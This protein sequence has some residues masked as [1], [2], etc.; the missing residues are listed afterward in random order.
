MLSKSLIQFYVD[1]LGCVPS[2]LFDPRTN[3]S[4]GNED[5][6]DLPQKVQQ[7]PV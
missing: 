6:G 1:G 7:R 3:Y 5:G 2:L 4:E